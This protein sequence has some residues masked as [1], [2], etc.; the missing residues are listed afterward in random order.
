V[1]QLSRTLSPRWINRA[2]CRYRSKLIMAEFTLWSYSEQNCRRFFPCCKKSNARFLHFDRS[3]NFFIQEIHEHLRP[4]EK[5]RTLHQE[6][7]FEYFF[8]RFVI[9]LAYEF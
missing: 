8:G 6:L 4:Q 7:K 2:L 9:F 5:Y 3:A 1:V